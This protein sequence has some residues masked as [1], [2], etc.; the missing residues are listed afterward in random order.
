MSRT[1]YSMK[2]IS[3][4][5]GMIFLILLMVEIGYR[6]LN[7]YPYFS[8]DEI[9]ETQHGNLS[10]YDPLLDGKAY[11]GGKNVLSLGITV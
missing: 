11:Q 1:M 2:R 4:F 9:N 8:D 3:L 10:E 6:I 5:I 7:P